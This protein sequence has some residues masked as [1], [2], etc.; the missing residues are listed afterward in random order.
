[1][2]RLILKGKLFGPVAQEVQSC[3]DAI[4]RIFGA[5]ATVSRVLPA[6]EGDFYC[7]LTVYSPTEG[8]NP[9]LTEAQR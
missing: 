8:V 3:A 5:N 1:M 2:A 6:R 9:M 4:Q 7:Y